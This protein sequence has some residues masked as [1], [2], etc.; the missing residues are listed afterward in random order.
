MV[1]VIKGKVALLSV[2]ALRE[3]RGEVIPP[4]KGRLLKTWKGVPFAFEQVG[5]I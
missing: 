4:A 3:D 2:F 5:S 1:G